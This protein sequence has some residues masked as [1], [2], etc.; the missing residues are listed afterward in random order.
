MKFF[1]MFLIGAFFI[2]LVLPRQPLRVRILA[3]AALCAFT[4]FG[5]YF[6]RQ[7]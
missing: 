4:A 6:L 1:M 2:G 3:V 7:I 5:Y